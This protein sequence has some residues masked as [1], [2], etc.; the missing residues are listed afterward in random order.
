M[1]TLAVAIVVLAGCGSSQGVITQDSVGG[2]STTAVGGTGG[3]PQIA[4]FTAQP[5]TISPGQASVLVWLVSD[6]AATL[7]I[8]NGVGTV[9]GT[10]QTVAPK[11]STVYTLTATNGAGSTSSHVAVSVAASSGSGATTPAIGTGVETVGASWVNDTG[12]LAGMASECGNMSYVSVRPDKDVV[13]AGVAHGGLWASTDPSTTV[14]TALGSGT[15]SAKIINRPSSFVYDPDHP[16]TWW[17]SGIYAGG[18]VYKTTDGGTTFAQLG[19]VT[20]SD[21]VSVD[22][23]DPAR[24]VLLSGKHESG[25]VDRSTDGGATWTAMTGLPDGIGYT[26][27]PYVV[28][29]TTYLLGT[30]NG[31]TS[32]IYRTT[33]SGATWVLAHAGGMLGHPL[34]TKDGRIWWV[35]ANGDL[36]SSTDQG[37]TWTTASSAALSN[38]SLVQLADGSLAAIVQDRLA[39]S[40]D[41]GVTWTAIGPTVP[42]TPSGIA[43]SAP[44][45]SFYVWHADCDFSRPDPVLPDA[46]MRLDADVS[47]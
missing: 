17:V 25:E 11:A 8:D 2:S 24:N 42:F 32:G 33:D 3:A 15:G 7:S 29:A 46:I 34:V 9:T 37:A 19:D 40:K 14:W 41:L 45:N 22:L 18:G 36:V 35:I 10:S 5:S 20:H 43:Y 44:R 21:L 27:A 39:T 1:A 23:T 28:N 30:V 26:T 38:G 31:A 47:G 4:S 16:D 6:P 12:N 13:I